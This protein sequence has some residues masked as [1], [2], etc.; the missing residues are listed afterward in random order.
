ML[1]EPEFD[2]LELEALFSSIYLKKDDSIKAPPSLIALSKRNSFEEIRRRPDTERVQEHDI[3]ELGKPSSLK[4][5]PLSSPSAYRTPPHRGAP[6]P[7][8]PPGG[9]PPFP[10]LPRGVPPPPPPPGAPAPPP[11]LGGVLRPPPPPRVP[12]PPGGPPSPPSRQGGGP[13]RG[14]GR[15]GLQVKKSNLK[16]LHWNKISK[17]LAGS[18]WTEFQTNNDAQSVPGFDM[19]E[20]ET[21]FS[22][23]AP[24]AA[25]KEDKKNTSSSKPEVVQLVD[26]RRASN[27]E[28]MLTKITMPVPEIVDAI[29]TLDERKLNIDQVENIYKF[30]PT[31][32]E[33]EKL[34]RYRGDKKLL[35]KCEQHLLELMKVPRIESKMLVFLFK[36]GFSN[37][38]AEFRKSLNI[39][40]S[41]CD[42]LRTSV[43]LKEIMKKILYMGNTLNQGTARGAAVGFK[44]DSLLKLT[45]TRSSTSKMTLMH[46]L[47]KVLASDY[48]TL[49]DFHKDLVSLE[50]ATKVQL[51]VLAEDMQCFIVGLR[52]VKLELDA[53]AEDGPISKGFH[54]MDR[55]TFCRTLI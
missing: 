32:E 37:Q 3:P 39:V 38:L 54:E 31:R 25:K 49:L 30:C 15:G 19:S 10:P 33:M 55:L 26:L 44:L 43:K 50:S 4:P 23:I 6:P 41:T 28:I 40:N 1:F 47:C 52:K 29:L 51:K 16:P 22:A 2:V 9:A 17:A 20:F 27:M 42:E 11:P 13:G 46:Y 12:G 18:L 24:K 48:P 35:G 14:R 7:P 8:P 53:S 45:D 21:L 36:T 34:E 5:L